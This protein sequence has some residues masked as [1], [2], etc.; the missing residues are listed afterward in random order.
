M[1]NS[2]AIG[3]GSNVFAAALTGAKVVDTTTAPC[4]QVDEEVA[5]EIELVIVDRGQIMVG[6][7][8]RGDRSARVEGTRRHRPRRRGTTSASSGVR[9]AA[10]MFC[11]RRATRVNSPV[12]SIGILGHALDRARAPAHADVVWKCRVGRVAECRIQNTTANPDTRAV[13]ISRRSPCSRSAAGLLRDRSATD[14]AERERP[15]PL[16]AFQRHPVHSRG[17]RAR[18]RMAE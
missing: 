14:R 7:I 9:P 17:D 15:T 16:V 5:L 6:G 2:K 11:F 18:R 1:L 8:E 13:D 3:M 10:A 12:A 4:V